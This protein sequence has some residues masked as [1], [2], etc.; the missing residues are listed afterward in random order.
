MDWNLL[1]EKTKNLTM[2]GVSKAKELG[3]IARLNL[4]NLSEEEKIKQTYVEIGMLYVKLHEGAPEEDY[5]PL[6]ERMEQAKANIQANKE[7]IARLRREGNIS[8]DDMQQIVLKDYED[9]D[10]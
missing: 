9:K 4:N 7:A 8:D 1:V 5:V 6:F 2:A 10:E 3:E